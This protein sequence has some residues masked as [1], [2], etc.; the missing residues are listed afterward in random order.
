MATHGDRIVRLL[1]AGQFGRVYEAR[2]GG[3]AYALKLVRILIRFAPAAA[4]L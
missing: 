4:D 1:G 2:I 3:T